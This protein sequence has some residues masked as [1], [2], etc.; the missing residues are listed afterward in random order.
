MSFKN[1]ILFLIINLYFL[2]CVGGLNRFKEVEI[3]IVESR[4]NQS[5]SST[6][7]TWKSNRKGTFLVKSNGDCR[8]GLYAVGSNISGNVEAN[9]P[10]ISIIQDNQSLPFDNLIYI[11]FTSINNL[12]ANKA[13]LLQREQNLSNSLE[14]DIKSSQI[15]LL[16]NEHDYISETGGY[17]S[18]DLVWSFY[19]TDLKYTIRIDG[20]DCKSGKLSSGKNG[21]GVTLKEPI[22]STI[23]A[24]DLSG[25]GKHIIRICVQNEDESYSSMSKE[26]TRDDTPPKVIN[27]TPSIE[28]ID[29]DVSLINQLIFTISEELGSIPSGIFS[30]SIL[31]NS[32]Y[33]NSSVTA[34]NKFI[35]NAWIFNEFSKPFFKNNQ[36]KVRILV[37][38][39][40]DLAGNRLNDII[41]EFNTKNFG[42]EKTWCQFAFSE[43]G[44]AF[45]AIFDFY[46]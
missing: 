16:S 34:Q 29:G 8:N 31:E 12:N 22:T 40:T 21:T 7:L 26:I 18:T 25:E 36:I 17:A 39:G 35:S 28:S 2:S 15:T 3:S 4:Y 42:A 27:V 6:F 43:A 32:K 19:K 10:I 45:S 38:E 14:T 44:C 33:I 13:Y 30:V 5:K 46:E 37:E 9:S 23:L 24:S 41:F 11:C 1:Y 20:K